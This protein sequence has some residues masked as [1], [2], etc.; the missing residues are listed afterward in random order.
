MK[1]SVGAA[2]AALSLAMAG[3]ANAQ[4]PP[5]PVAPLPSCSVLPAPP[6]AP[7]G[8]TARRADLEAATIAYNAWLADYQAKTA[9]CAADIATVRTQLNAS[10]DTANAANAAATAAGVDWNR[11]LAEYQARGNS[12]NRRERGSVNTRPDD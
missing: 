3:I 1:L 7:D 8:A 4:T 6:T 10:V 12:G 9:T 11:E 2:V 5:A